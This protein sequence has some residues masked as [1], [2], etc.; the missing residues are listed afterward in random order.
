MVLL[1]NSTKNSKSANLI[2]NASESRDEENIFNLFYE[3]ST[4][5]N[6]TKTLQKIPRL[7]SP[8]NKDVKIPNR[9]LAN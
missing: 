2:Q 9:M 7:I 6:L 4:T 3:A 1:A 8:I 5:K